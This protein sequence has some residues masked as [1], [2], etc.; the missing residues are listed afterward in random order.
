MCMLVC[1]NVYA[2]YE[3]F[4]EICGAIKYRLNMAT[5]DGYRRPVSP[6]STAS[7]EIKHYVAST[8]IDATGVKLSGPVDRLGL[9]ID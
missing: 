4:T 2:K 3:Q 5:R 7:I 9:K 6:G 1:T 8:L